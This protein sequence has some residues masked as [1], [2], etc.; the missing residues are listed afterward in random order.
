MKRSTKRVLAALLGMTLAVGCLAGCG[1]KVTDKTED[2]KTILSLGDCADP[3]TDPQKYEIELES[4]KFFE[5]THPHIKLKPDTYR[6]D[7]R[8]YIAKAN[9]GTMPTTYYVPPTEAK[10]IMDNGYAADLT[11]E[12]KKRGFYENINEFI[13]ENISRDGKIYF[14]PGSLYSLGLVMNAEALEAA[15]YMGEDGTPVEPQTWEEMAEMAKKIKEVTGKAGFVLT[16]TQNAGGWL[17]TPI[18]WSYGVEFM[19][20]DENGK[21]KATFDSPEMVK[22]LQFVSDLKWKYDV[23]P[24]NTLVD[25][26]EMEKL[27]GTGEGAMALMN[28]SSIDNL[29]K[30]GFATDNLAYVRL[31]AGPERRVTLMGGS[32]YVVDANAT[33]DQISAAFDYRE[34]CGHS[35]KLTDDIKESIKRGIESRKASNK[36]VGLVSLSPWKAD[37]EVEEYKAKV[38]AENA[39]INMNRVKF[40]NDKDGIEYQAEEPVEAQALYA[41]LDSCI[42]EVLNN[43]NADIAAL[44]KKSAEDF[45]KNQLDYVQ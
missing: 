5:E 32:Y 12:F 4:F 30:Y 24:A 28:P 39:N 10:S 7:T 31:P 34:Y 21:W 8:T 45:Q 11:A 2:G 15:G 22:A 23:I 25:N 20:K 6:F 27:I 18:A 29:S 26:T 37:C 43:K 19:K 41:V 44:V 33:E 42:Q 13:L 3:E 36:V 40:Y 1:K 35:T 16:T 17:F 38:Y 14:L 9:G